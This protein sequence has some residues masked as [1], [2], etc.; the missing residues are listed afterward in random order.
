MAGYV[1]GLHAVGGS[2]A[3][4]GVF[5]LALEARRDRRGAFTELFRES[6]IPSGRP[7]QWN[8]LRSAAHTL[9]GIH[10]HVRHTDYVAPLSGTAIVGLKDLRRASPT[11]LEDTHLALDASSARLLRIPP[12]VA[13]GFYFPCESL[14][15][16]ATTDYFDPADDLGYRWDDPGATLFPDVR[17]PILSD[18]D[19]DAQDFTALMAELEPHQA[20]LYGP[21]RAGLRA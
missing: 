20:F 18:R 3:L 21:S 14:L 8:V 15:S 17:A 12:G 11:F 7:L 10:V 4:D 6:W 16:L 1:A 9:R 13:H 2:G 19:E 5:T